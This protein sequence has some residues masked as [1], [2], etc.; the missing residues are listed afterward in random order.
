[1]HAR[2][3]T[4]FGATGTQGSSVVK[5]LLADGTFTPRA[6]TRNPNSEKALKLKELGAEVVQADLWDVPSL[7]NA[8][9]GVEGVFGVTDYYDP[10]NSAQGH[11]SEVLLGKN[12]VDAA[13][14]SDVKF[15]VWSSLPH[16][17]RI[18]NGK[19]PNIYHF[20]N[21]ANVDEYL[22]DSK[23]PH[24]IVHTGWFAE[25]TVN[26]HSLTL[27]PDSSSYALTI[28]KYDPN[29]PQYVTWVERDLGQCV[30]ALLKHYKDSSAG[31]LDETFYAVSD[32]LTYTEYAAVIEKA[33]GKP[34]R[35]VSGPPSGMQELDEMYEFQSE[36]GMYPHTPIPDPR[37]ER[38]G[39][40]FNS[41]E[42][43]AQEELKKRFA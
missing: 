4:V 27:S 26:F 17:T 13:V 18:S 21:K 37:L 30:L 1:M 35:F 16:S 5:A 6:V 20:D 41:M 24:S 3:V 2:V 11:T 38:L 29:T 42:A 32:K 36:F 43:Y 8:M 14:E 25:N 33:L 19:Y 39:V 12:L 31:V 15:F 10:K 9:S 23:L 28:P 22:R 7:K 34:V 40:K